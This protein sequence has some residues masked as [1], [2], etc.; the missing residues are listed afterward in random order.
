MASNQEQRGFQLFSRL[1]VELQLQ[2]ID[3]AIDPENTIF[4]RGWERLDSLALVS[5]QW[6]HEVDKALL[7][8]SHE[9]TAG[10]FPFLERAAFGSRFQ[11]IKEFRF[12]IELEGLY[13]AS[14]PLDSDYL[15][16]HE[17]DEARMSRTL[18]GVFARMFNVLARR[19]PGGDPTCELSRPMEI[20][21]GMDIGCDL[22]PESMS[23][24]R[25][26]DFNS[27]PELHN[28]KSWSYT[29]TPFVD[30]Y[31]FN[32]SSV[33]QASLVSRLPAL[34]SYEWLVEQSLEDADVSSEEDSPEG[35]HY[36]SLFF[37][38]SFVPFSILTHVSSLG[39]VSVYSWQKHHRPPNPKASL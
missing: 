36:H 22:V 4:G 16:V 18:D 1:P 39:Q 2:V 6:N 24:V 35:K 7:T 15:E 27:L 29:A 34:E 33:A 13:Q 21:Y 30:K 11:K 20:T 32:L 12:S 5:H 23:R 28:V 31:L 19:N 10:D 25:E 26:V 17:D 38:C 14:R 9:W 3:S 8:Y 37:F